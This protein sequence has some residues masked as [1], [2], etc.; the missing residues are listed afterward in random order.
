MEQTTSMGIKTT[1]VTTKNTSSSECADTYVNC[2]YLIQSSTE[3]CKNP[4]TADQCRS[5]CNICK[6][7]S[8]K[9]LFRCLILRIIEF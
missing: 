2:K 8:G 1:R 3:I 7:L 9:F 6:K 5:S 4:S